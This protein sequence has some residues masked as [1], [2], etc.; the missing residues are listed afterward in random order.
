MKGSE[1]GTGVGADPRPCTQGILVAEVI[2]YV[3]L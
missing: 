2:K 1:L 3:H